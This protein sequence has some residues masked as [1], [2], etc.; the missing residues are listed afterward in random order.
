MAENVVAEPDL[1][2]IFEDSGDKGSFDGFTGNDSDSD[3]DR[4]GLEDEGGGPAPGG[5]TD[6]K[7]EE[8]RWTDHLSDFRVPP[9][10]APTGL[11]FNLPENPNPLGTGHYL[12]PGG[13][14]R[15]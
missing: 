7:E 12:S 3:V 2:T 14:W 1:A 9:F 15:I 5:I 10:T 4:D 11:T 13:E 6:N 8:A